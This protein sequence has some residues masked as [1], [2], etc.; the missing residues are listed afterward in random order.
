M[1]EVV[2]RHRLSPVNEFLQQ[3]ADKIV[4][5]HSLIP[6]PEVDKLSCQTMQGPHAAMS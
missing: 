3:P 4:V 2:S 6:P 5:D 1:N